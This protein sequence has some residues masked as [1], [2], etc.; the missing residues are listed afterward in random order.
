MIIIVISDHSDHEIRTVT[1]RRVV[2][3]SAAP[4]T[5]Y[6]PPPCLSWS[7]IA[8]SSVYT[9]S[10]SDQE[11]ISMMMIMMMMMMLVRVKCS[12]A[13]SVS[14]VLPKEDRK[15][16]NTTGKWGAGRRAMR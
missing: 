14:I 10:H 13:A 9:D 16:L 2:N 5:F 12:E 4:P 11:T 15:T 8:L 3:T 1:R 7:N 6:Y